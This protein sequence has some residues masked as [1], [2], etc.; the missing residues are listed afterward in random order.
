[1]SLKQ[2]TL[3]PWKNV[4]KRYPVGSTANAVIVNVVNYGAFAQLA[5]GIV[6]LNHISKMS[7]DSMDASPA[8]IVNAGDKIKVRVIEISK[9]HKRISLSMT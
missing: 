8:N 5:E 2:T 3:G 4:E 1:M 6:G 9:N 7:T